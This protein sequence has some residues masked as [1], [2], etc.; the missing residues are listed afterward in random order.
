MRLSESD[1]QDATRKHVDLIKD[2]SVRQVTH[3]NDVAEQ[4]YGRITQCALAVKEQE[5]ANARFHEQ[6]ASFV[7]TFTQAHQV[8]ETQRLDINRRNEMLKAQETRLSLRLR[9]LKSMPWWQR[10]WSAL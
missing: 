4:L 10:L 5:M 6:Q 2:V 8:L 3:L 7:A 9:E 1:L